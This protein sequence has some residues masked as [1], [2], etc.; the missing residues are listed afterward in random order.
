MVLTIECMSKQR[1]YNMNFAKTLF[2]ESDTKNGEFII[3]LKNV[4]CYICKDDCDMRPIGLEGESPKHINQ[5]LVKY[6][7]GQKTFSWDLGSSNWQII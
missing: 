1:P 7:F 6:L 4:R 5:I 2:S 3:N